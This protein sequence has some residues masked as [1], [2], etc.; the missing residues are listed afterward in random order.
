MV[1]NPAGDWHPGSGV[2][3]SCNPKHEGNARFPWH[4]LS[5]SNGVICV[6]CEVVSPEEWS[7]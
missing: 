3:V 2:D 5:V 1:H 4:P 6:G 7:K